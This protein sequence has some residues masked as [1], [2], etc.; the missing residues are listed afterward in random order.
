MAANGAT[1]ASTERD[2]CFDEVHELWETW[3]LDPPSV[4]RAAL[5]KSGREHLLPEVVLERC[6]RR[7]RMRGR[8]NR[9]KMRAL[10]GKTRAPRGQCPGPA[11]GKQA[12]ASPPSP[13]LKGQ[14]GSLPPAT[15]CRPCLPPATPCRPCQPTPRRADLPPVHVPEPAPM[16]RYEFPPAS[17]PAPM[18]RYAFPPASEPAPV[19]R[20]A[21]PPAPEPAPVVRYAYPPASEPEEWRPGQK[22]LCEPT[23]RTVSRWPLMPILEVAEEDLSWVLD[24]AAFDR[25]PLA[26]PPGL[27]PDGLLT[28][29]PP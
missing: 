10:H 28:V 4:Y 6:R 22:L 25:P 12:R 15:P 17:E 11:A 1:A 26:D 27:E 18:V 3:H 7:A 9:L 14:T 13:V 24:C 29:W 20:Y 23:Q 2:R 16:V 19:V 5:K 21:F 8:E